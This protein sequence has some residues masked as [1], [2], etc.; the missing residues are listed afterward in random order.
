MSVLGRMLNRIPST[1]WFVNNRDFI[2]SVLEAEKSKV[3]VPTNFGSSFMHSAFSLQ[4]P[5]TEQ[6]VLSMGSSLIHDSS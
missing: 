3:K 5:V 6:N 2:A 4:S 1:R